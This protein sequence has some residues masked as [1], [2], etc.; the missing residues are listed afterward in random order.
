MALTA[1]KCPNCEANIQVDDDRDFGFCS[2]CGAQIQIREVIEV[3]YSKLA[4]ASAEE[5][6]LRKL[7]AGKAFHKMEDYHKAEMIYMEMLREY[8]GRP[9]VYEGLICTITRNYTLFISENVERAYKLM[10]KMVLVAKEEDKQRYAELQTKVMRWY[11]EGMTRQA[12]EENLMEIAKLK[13]MIREDIIIASFSIVC[14]IALLGKAKGSFFVAQLGVL[15]C[16]VAV[17][18]V[19]MYVKNSRKKDQLLKR[20]QQ[21]DDGIL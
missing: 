21:M 12:K 16:C 14:A 7:D 13:K 2:Y 15:I 9:E 4:E 1:L 20:N 5:E 19:V 3:S 11:D 8:P 17:W 6:F 18:A 10:D